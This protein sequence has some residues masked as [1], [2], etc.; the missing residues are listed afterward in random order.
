MSAARP[1]GVIFDLDGTLLDSL[2]GIAGAMNRTLER[3][4]FPVHPAEAYQQ[5]IGE[6]VQ[7]LA[8]RAMPPGTEAQRSELV[9]VYQEDYAENLFEQT[10]LYPGI[11]EMLDGL[12]ACGV[13]MAVL[14]NKPDAATK[15]LMATLFGRWPFRG[16]L[17]ERAGIPRKPDPTAALELA[18][19]LDRPPEWVA[20]VGDTL[21]DVRTARAAGMR[22][23]GVLWGFRTE[24]VRSAG[25]PIA[26]APEALLPLLLPA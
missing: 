9:R 1:D 17:G 14:S 3:F 12:V 23:V 5:L 16:A 20:F 11:A 15:E 4:G 22:P 24:E 18:R 6:G 25:I 2:G 19:L 8:E 21:V 10:E 26:E 7:R 13:P